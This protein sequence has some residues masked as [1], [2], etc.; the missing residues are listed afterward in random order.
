MVYYKLILDDKRS[1]V[2][3]I[4]PVVIRVTSNR[5]ATT[6]STGIRVNVQHWDKQSSS[7]NKT[8][9]NWQVL[10]QSLID[11]YAKVQREILKLQDENTFSI[12]S[13][14]A[15]LTEQDSSKKSNLK[16][17]F[18]QFVE[19]VISELKDLNKSGNAFDLPDSLE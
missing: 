17:S 8:H 1:K 4:Y 6:I 3:E 5:V 2:D 9:P 18:N 14:K 16:N 13:L 10:N 7:I 11:F 12:E 19:Q 15:R